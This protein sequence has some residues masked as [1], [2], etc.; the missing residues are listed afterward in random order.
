MY[1]NKLLQELMT[2]D[3]IKILENVKKIHFIGIG[4]IGMS[5]IAEYLVKKDF[6]VSGSDSTLSDLTERLSELGVEISEGHNEN[7]FSDNTDLI[8][9]SAAIKDDNSELIKANRLNIKA[10]KRAKMLGEIVNDSYLIAVSG[11]H[12]K[13]ST[14]AMIAKILI[15]CGLDPTVFVGGT[16]DFLEGGNSRI[17]NGK[18]AIVE[19]D[20]YDKSFL[21]LKPDI[22]IITNID[23]DHTD[24]Y[25]DLDDL[26][27][28]FSEFLKGGKEN[29]KV[30]GFGDDRNVIDAMN[31]V[32]NKNCITYGFNKHNN[33]IIEE[34]YLKKSNI[35]FEINGSFIEL[36][37]PGRHNVLNS[38]AAYISAELLG[39]AKE[40]IIRCL[41]SFYGVNRRL[42]LKYNK[43][44]MVYDDYAHHP[45]EIE[46]SFY[47]IKEI[48]K[49]RVIT[50]FQ[51]HTFTRTR[52]FYEGFAVALKN[53]DITILTDLYPAREK[54]I[55]GISSKLI[56]DKLM[57]IGDNKSYYE[58]KFDD[59]IKRLDEVV[60]ENDTI[61][62]QGAGDITNLCSKYVNK[63]N[64]SEN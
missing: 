31:S 41:K 26:K 60:K 36:S 32:Q 44:I 55:K 6:I 13:T 35:R 25:K 12:G 11:T 18:Y 50:V 38:S 34:S 14:T 23:L 53:N 42:E 62:F 21:T 63:L 52:D 9:Y 64:E 4:G 17:G 43:E 40:C 24:I 57:L 29:M 16:I 33:H 1:Q 2:K 28:T 47:A 10:I 37:V 45:T 30:I 19:A 49:S 48:A 54:E 22:A 3:S 5:G 58:P 61:I 51:P 20:E 15:D 7:N 39:I 8:V 46:Y 27:S 59:V 56:F